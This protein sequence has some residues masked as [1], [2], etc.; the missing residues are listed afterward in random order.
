MDYETVQSQ[1]VENTKTEKNDTLDP[2]SGR[3]IKPPPFLVKTYD[4]VDDPGTNSYVTWNP[5]GTGFIISDHNKF[6][7]NVLPTI[8]K[9]SNFSSFV[10]QLNSYGFKKT[11]WE[12]YEYANQWFQAGKK[13]WLVNIKRRDQLLSEWSS[14][15]GKKRPRFAPEQNS[16]KI[17][18]EAKVD[19]LI[20]EQKDMKL[21]IHKL[22]QSFNSMEEQ[23][24]RLEIQKFPEFVSDK[25][26]TFAIFLRDFIKYLTK[27]E[28]RKASDDDSSRRPR[29]EAKG[30]GAG[31]N[32]QKS[33]EKLFFAGDDLE[34]SIIQVEKVNK[35]THN[36]E[37]FQNWKIPEDQAGFDPKEGDAEL[38]SPHSED[39]MGLDEMIIEMQKEIV[40][41]NSK[42]FDLDEE[43]DGHFYLWT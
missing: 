6:S 20:N 28:K 38:A 31:E 43:E 7:A 25:T 33:T 32:A 16:L 5:T 30:G 29:S 17:G 24:A 21:E 19:A 8:F 22:E 41:P 15:S 12:R 27:K 9:T 11:S 39:M 13:H 42:P 1:N 2:K 36:S 26:N 23:I 4:M 35:S 34:C 18:M 3:K 37:N 10:Y 40:I 14:K